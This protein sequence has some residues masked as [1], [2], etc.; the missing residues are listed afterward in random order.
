MPCYVVYKCFGYIK[1]DELEKLLGQG[2]QW[3]QV[4]NGDDEKG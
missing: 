2:G 3:K 4:K 1:D